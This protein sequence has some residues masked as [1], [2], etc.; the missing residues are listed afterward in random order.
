MSVKNQERK[1][2]AFSDWIL[3]QDATGSRLSLNVGGDDTFNTHLGAVFSIVK[4]GFCVFWVAMRLHDLV[5]RASPAYSRHTEMQDMD[6]ISVKMRENEFNFGVAIFSVTE[7]KNIKWEPKFGELKVTI[8]EMTNGVPN[9][10]YQKFRECNSTDLYFNGSE[11]HPY[12]Q[13]LAYC[14][15]RPEDLYWAGQ[16]GASKQAEFTVTIER[17]EWE[18]SERKTWMEDKLIRVSGP[19]NFIDVEKYDVPFSTR[20]QD[21]VDYNFPQPNTLDIYQTLSVQVV[22]ASIENRQWS[23]FPFP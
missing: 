19:R 11:A 8:L 6:T 17:G 22:E 1:G 5:L 16:M 13:E 23:F 18:D 4:W 20:V 21:M 14:P 12:E 7:N 3:S 15:E 10:S 2:N 9:V